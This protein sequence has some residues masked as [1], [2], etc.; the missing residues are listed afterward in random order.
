MRG[1]ILFITEYDTEA[2]KG[3]KVWLY[4]DCQRVDLSY[5][6]QK[7]LQARL[8]EPEAVDAVLFH[9]KLVN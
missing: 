7:S 4:P 5:H 8:F 6:L 1:F 9:Q 2:S 3:F